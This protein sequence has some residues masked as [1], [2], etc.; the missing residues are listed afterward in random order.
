MHVCKQENQRQSTPI[1]SDSLQSISLSDSL[2]NGC[3]RVISL[4]MTLHIN[5]CGNHKIKIGTNYK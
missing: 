4:L 2:L 1:N 3:T 5:K